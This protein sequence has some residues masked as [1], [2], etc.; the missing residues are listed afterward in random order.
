MGQDPTY[1]ASQQSLAIHF[2]GGRGERE[3]KA[4]YPALLKERHSVGGLKW[5]CGEKEVFS[6]RSA[7]FFCK[8]PNSNILGFGGH[9]WSMLHV[10]LYLF[11][12]FPT[13]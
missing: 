4:L 5:V 7:N 11:V 6:P 12:C 1:G 3:V 8:D 2:S 13:L 9:T 10:L